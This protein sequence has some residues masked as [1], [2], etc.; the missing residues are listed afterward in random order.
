MMF[1]ILLCSVL[2]LAIVAE[3]SWT[4]RRG[5]IMPSDLLARTRGLVT[6]NQLTENHLRQLHS[7][8]LG[9]V[10]AAGLVHRMQ[11]R[12]AIKDAIED[13]GSHVAHQLERYL[14]ALGTIANITPLLGLLGTVMGMISVFATISSTG[15]G[16]AQA[17]AGGISQALITTAA[18]LCVAIP[19]LVAHRY[20]RGRVLG[21]VVEMEQ[22]ALKLIDTIELQ[23]K[24]G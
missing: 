20:L 17:L 15:V 16:D 11:P 23:K 1:P 9:K 6:E 14:T 18:G 22:A 8:P 4:L 3:R 10:L 2:A 5:Q 13:V 21:Y 19:S 12:E 24:K 7:S